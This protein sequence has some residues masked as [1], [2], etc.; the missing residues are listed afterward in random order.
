MAFNW[1]IISSEERPLALLMPYLISSNYEKKY[2][3]IIFIMHT[4]LYGLCAV[5]L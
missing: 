2:C 3:D 4:I 5:F 1:H